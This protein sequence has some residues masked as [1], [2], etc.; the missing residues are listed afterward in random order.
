MKEADLRKAH[1][2]YLVWIFRIIWWL[3][4]A[5]LSNYCSLGY[6]FTKCPF[7]CQ[8]RLLSQT[9]YKPQ[10]VLVFLWI[11]GLHKAQW[12]FDAVMAGQHSTQKRTKVK[13]FF[14]DWSINYRNCVTYS[15][16]WCGYKP[17]KNLHMETLCECCTKHWGNSLCSRGLICWTVNI[18]NSRQMKKIHNL[19]NS[20]IVWYLSFWTVLFT[21]LLKPPFA[22]FNFLN[23]IKE[24]FLMRLGGVQN[25]DRNKPHDYLL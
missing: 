24:V 2:L 4:I 3:W 19:L 16:C 8:F 10:Q 21:I 20:Q 23:K 17:Q 6:H 14:D 11:S 25:T 13:S 9:E 18:L 7:F 5:E 1:N 12:T 15:K 22:H